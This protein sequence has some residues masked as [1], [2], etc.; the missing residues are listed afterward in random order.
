MFLKRP[1]CQHNKWAE[2]YAKSWM[3]YDVFIKV[4]MSLATKIFLKTSG[5]G[6]FFHQSFDFEKRRSTNFHNRGPSRG[7]CESLNCFF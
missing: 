5:V 1:V 6:V 7:T 4:W 2:K 3:S